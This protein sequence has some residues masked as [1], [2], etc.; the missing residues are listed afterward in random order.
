MGNQIHSATEYRLATRLLRELVI[1]KVTQVFSWAGVTGNERTGLLAPPPPT[2]VPEGLDWNLWIGAAPMREHAPAYHPFTWRDWQD[3]GGG[4]LGDFGCHIL[5]PVFTGL[6]LSAPRSVQARNSGLNDQI[7]PTQEKVTYVF[8]GTQWTAGDSVTVTWMDGGLKPLHSLAR[9][10][11][12]VDLPASGSLFV[13]EEGCM[14]LPHVG[15]PQ[16]YPVEKYAGTGKPLE[17]DEKRNHWHD[18]VDA[19]LAGKKTSDGFHY[20]GPLSEAVH[21]GN[22]ATRLSR[23]VRDPLTGR[24]KDSGSEELQWDAAALRFSGPQAAEAERLASKEY[25]SGFEVPAAPA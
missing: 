10:P 24:L 9:M 6:G 23:P 7:W 21:I 14:V 16:L 1:G 19:C 3:F 2:P 13:G 12:A 8:P 4:A 17:Q 25:R 5:D 11:G 20:A 18:W 22:I 15:L